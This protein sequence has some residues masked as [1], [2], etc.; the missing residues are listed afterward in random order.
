MRRLISMKAYRRLVFVGALIIACILIIDYSA[1]YTTIQAERQQLISSWT[2]RSSSERSKVH[3]DEER[4]PRAFYPWIGD[5]GQIL[6]G[7]KP[8]IYGV[9]VLLDLDSSISETSQGRGDTLIER[10]TDHDFGFTSCHQ[11][12]SSSSS[13]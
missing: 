13:S 12:T 4:R 3:A 7:T 8:P 11:V 10:L 1:L 9:F 6:N 2:T 5:S